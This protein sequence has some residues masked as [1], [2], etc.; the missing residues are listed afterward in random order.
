MRKEPRRGVAAGERGGPGATAHAREAR[1]ARRSFSFLHAPL[2]LFLRIS[3]ALTVTFARVCMRACHG[4]NLAL[5]RSARRRMRPSCRG[6]PG[7][8]VMPRGGWGKSGALTAD[9]CYVT[10]APLCRLLDECLRETYAR[11]GIVT[12]LQVTLNRA[13]SV[14]IC[15]FIHYYG[16]PPA[17]R[18]Y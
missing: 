8:S 10:A 6:D 13:A 18:H 2:L 12:S 15:N 9:A 5:L 11:G 3:R 17:L 7:I 1:S 4:R 16:N 14:D